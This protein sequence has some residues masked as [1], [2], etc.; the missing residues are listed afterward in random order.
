MSEFG[1]V[2]LVGTGPGDPGLMTMRAVELIAAADAI[3]YDRLI[4][5]G[6]LAGA[7]TGAVLRYV[8]KSPG[9]EADADGSTSQ[10]EIVAQLIAAAAEHRVVLRLKGGDPFVFGRGGEEAEALYETGVPFE[11]VPGVTAGIAGPAYAGIPVTS[12]GEAGAVA[13][14]TGHPAGEI[15]KGSAASQGSSGPAGDAGRGSGTDGPDWRALAPFPGT[16]IFYMGVRR[17][18]ENCAA[19]IE[20]GRSPLEPAAVIESATLPTQRLIRAPLGEL[21]EAAT[22]AGVRAP[23][24]VVTG[25]VA[26]LADRLAWFEPGPLA[27][28]VVAVTRARPQAATT[29]ARLRRLGAEVVELPAIRV[30]S[31]LNAAAVAEAI[32]RLG[33]GEFDLLTLTSVN[34]VEFL[35]EALRATGLD[36][37]A[38]AGTRVAAIGPATVTALAGHGIEADHEPVR[39]VAESLLE[40]LADLDLAGRGVLVAG[41][42]GMR[43]T[44]PEGLATRGAQVTRLALYETVPEPLDERQLAALREADFITI[45]SASAAA[46][47]ARALTGATPP[48]GRLVSIGPITSAAAREEGLVVDFEATEH[49]IEGLMAI[50]L[51]HA[52][53]RA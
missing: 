22:E 32:D 4:P 44:L 37:R 47:L 12:R 5:A 27:G 35:F 30:E 40:A 25:A 21:A 28:R 14:V 46:N 29:S 13:F 39:A 11:V 8:G 20:A 2:Y 7:P 31:R 19:L 24:L 45:A 36:A 51:R 50:I 49:T 1:T 33:R 38:L 34:G 10:D 53:R 41:A 18:A 26:S 52:S 48:R 3:F 15:D 42:A 43:G 9:V 17:L 23:A 6:A 16:L